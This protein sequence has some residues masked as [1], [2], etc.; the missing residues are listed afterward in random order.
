MATITH[1]IKVQR[2]QTFHVTVDTADG[3]AGRERAERI[4]RQIVMGG[5]VKP[6]LEEIVN[7]QIV[8]LPK[9]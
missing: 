5:N 9:K 1:T 7:T 6:D 8:T 4:A 2:L 3:Q